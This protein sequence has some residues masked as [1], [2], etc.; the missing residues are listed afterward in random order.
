MLTSSPG[1]DGNQDILIG[2]SGRPPLVLLPVHDVPRIQRRE[3]R[4]LRG[5]RGR[6]VRCSSD[7]RRGSR[8]EVLLRRG[9]AGRGDRCRGRSFAAAAGRPRLHR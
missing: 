2:Q 5:G 8:L 9:A 3:Q 6:R 7:V 1:T 4:L